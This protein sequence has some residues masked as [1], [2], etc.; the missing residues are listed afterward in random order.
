[1]AIVILIIDVSRITSLEA[2]VI[3]PTYMFY[4]VPVFLTID[5]DNW[6]ARDGGICERDG[7]FKKYL[8]LPCVKNC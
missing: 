1:M 3:I 7:I 4:Q 2:L 6:S 8:G 5:D